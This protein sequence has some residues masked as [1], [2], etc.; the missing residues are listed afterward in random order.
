MHLLVNHTYCIIDICNEQLDRF[1]SM[2]LTI[3]TRIRIKYILWFNGPIVIETS[4][5]L[6]A[7]RRKEMEC[8][9][10]Q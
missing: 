6:I 5:R 9:K 4:K 7:L 8:L 10:L 1:K 2:G 3:N